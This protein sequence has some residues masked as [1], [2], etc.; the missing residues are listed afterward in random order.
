MTVET[1][2]RACRT[3]V[4][5]SMPRGSI[6][7]RSYSTKSARRGEASATCRGVVSGSRAPVLGKKHMELF[8]VLYVARVVF[9]QCSPYHRLSPFSLHP[10]STGGLLVAIVSV[11]FSWTVTPLFSGWKIAVY[12]SS[13]NL[14]TLINDCRSCGN[15]CASL[16]LLLSC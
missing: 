6:S 13:D 9:Y 3:N 11:P 7:E 8:F 5:H 14:F 16:A 15:T 1:E 10:W 12:P 4:M 2:S